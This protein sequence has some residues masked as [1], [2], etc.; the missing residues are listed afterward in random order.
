M[1]NVTLINP[2]E[3]DAEQEQEFLEKWTRATEF[4]RTQPGFVSSELHRSVEAD[5]HFRF[6]NVAV[7]ESAEHFRAAIN[8]RE[9]AE[10]A[11][12]MPFPHYPALYDIFLHAGKGEPRIC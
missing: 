1:A 7:W 6:T 8:S 4:L 2:F 3:I 11:S 9:F 12:T 5:A 10:L